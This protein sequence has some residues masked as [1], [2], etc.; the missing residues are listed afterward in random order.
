MDERRGVLYIV[1]TPIGNLDDITLRA[2]EVLGKVDRIAAEDTRQVRKLL[3][4]HGIEARVLEP[5]HAHNEARMAGRLAARLESGESMALVTDAGT[6]GVSDP[7]YLLVKAALRVGATVEAIPGASA[8]LAALT[9]SG[10]PTDHFLFEGFPPRRPG[11]RRRALVRLAELP[12]SL[13]FFEAPAR[14][15]GF[16]TDVLAVLGDRPLAVARELTKRHEEIWRGTVAEYLEASLPPPRG[17][18]TVV[19]AGRSR[20]ERVRSGRSSRPQG[21]MR[22]PPPTAIA[23]R[24]PAS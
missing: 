8:V 6:P 18:V 21:G 12:H 5:F 3:D 11:A 15:R 9:S 10:L 16:L 20:A 24:T 17:E 7:A 4:R 19:I 22:R 2:L 1:A 13:V 23:A 14:L